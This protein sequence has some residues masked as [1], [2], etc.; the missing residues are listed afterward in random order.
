MSKDN[1]D[2]LDYIVDA[3]KKRDEILVQDKPISQYNKY[4]KIMRKY[5]RKLIDDGRQNELLPY[6]EDESISIRADIACLLFHLY[7]DRCTEILQYISELTRANGL[8][9]Y[10]DLVSVAAYNNLKYGI[11]KDFP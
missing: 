1:K 3:I 7:P 9:A 5:A 4:F 8:P 11:P 10:F 2:T 6:L